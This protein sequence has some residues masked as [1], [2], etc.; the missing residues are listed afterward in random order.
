M[1]ERL[2]GI[3]SDE[4]LEKNERDNSAQEENGTQIFHLFQ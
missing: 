3:E 4:G 2:G 1:Q